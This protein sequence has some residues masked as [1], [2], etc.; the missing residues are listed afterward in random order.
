MINCTG[1]VYEWNRVKNHIRRI[2]K[3]F[4]AEPIA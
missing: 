1:Q 4:F 2:D 3:T